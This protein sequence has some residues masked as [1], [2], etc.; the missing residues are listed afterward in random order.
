MSLSGTA[1]FV[2]N[3]IPALNRGG[4]I[5]LV[6]LFMLTAAFGVRRKGGV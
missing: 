6:V 1:V 5:L 2:A 4:L 3:L